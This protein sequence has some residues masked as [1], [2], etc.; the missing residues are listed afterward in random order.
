VWLTHFE[1]DLPRS[2]LAN[3]LIVQAAADQV[4]VDN[5]RVAV[6][7]KNVDA[8]CGSEGSI[9]PFGT[10]PDR[11]GPRGREN[12]VVLVGLGLLSLAALARRRL[13]VV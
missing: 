11:S 13:A 12:L 5:L 3:D 7:A 9:V 4:K 8:V 6:I 1:A 10:N 2:A